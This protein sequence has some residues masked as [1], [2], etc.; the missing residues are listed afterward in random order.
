MAQESTGSGQFSNAEHLMPQEER[1]ATITRK[2]NFTIGVPK[3]TVYQEMR[4]SL[5]PSSIRLLIENGNRVLVQ[6]GAGESALFSD[7][8]YSESGAEIV[9]TQQEVYQSDIII[10]VAP[11]T[12]LEISL[13]KPKSVIISALHLRGQNVNYFKALSEK[14]ITALSYEH[15][16]DSTGAHPLMQSISEIV[17]GT[18]I[19]LGAEFLSHPQWGRGEMLGGFSGICPTEV[20]ILGA[21]TVAEFAAKAAL[22]LGA[23]VKV[24][25]NSVLRLRKLQDHINNRIYTSILQPD[26]L[27]KSLKTAD[28]V[29]AALYAHNGNSVV[30]GTENMVKEMKQGSVIIDVSIDR[31]GCFETSKETNHVNPVYQVHGVTHYCVPNIS[32]RTPHTSSYA[33]NNYFTPLL[34]EIC[35]LGSLNELLLADVGLRKGVYMYNGKVTIEYISNKFNL[36][37]QDIGLLL[38]AFG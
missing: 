22:G 12:L 5:V 25:D 34:L 31:G 30:V 2:A 35:G 28:L 21:G 10:K 17:G 14:R 4:V 27:S 29:I 20:V 18:S 3:E 23:V 36:P 24:F 33:L 11:P 15:I 19:L 16:Q 6:R 8:Q 32:S 37:Y 7:H 26:I 9:E 1:L 13:M 38:A